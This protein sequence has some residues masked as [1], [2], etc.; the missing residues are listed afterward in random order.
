MTAGSTAASN[1]PDVCGSN[2][3]ASRATGAV[4][5]TRPSRYVRLRASPPVRALRAARA[6]WQARD[7]RCARL[8]ALHHRARLVLLWSLRLRSLVFR[9]ERRRSYQEGA[10][11]LASSDARSL[12]R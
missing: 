2:A 9:G 4:D 3:S 7:R 10:R 6:R 1:P 5:V 11:F 12:T 8:A